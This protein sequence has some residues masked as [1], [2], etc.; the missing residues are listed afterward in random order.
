LRS[1]S[2]ETARAIVE[3]IRRARG[4]GDLVIASIHW[5]SNWGWEIGDDQIRFAH[6]LVDGGVDLVHGHS[7]HHPRAIEL[8]QGRLILYGCGA[9][10][11]DYEG[12]SGHEEFRDD[13]RLMYFATLS[14]STG[15]LEA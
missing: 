4:P 1:F 8:Y 13:L 3:H 6:Q 14:V 9:F 11:D 7:S 12:I 10:I 2:D 15:A 5:G